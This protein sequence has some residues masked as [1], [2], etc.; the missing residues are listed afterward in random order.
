[1]PSISPNR[2]QPRHPRS[3]DELPNSLDHRDRGEHPRMP[4]HV[5]RG[6]K[7]LQGRL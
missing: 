7:T 5:E 4:S 2:K 1:M 3:T 6:R